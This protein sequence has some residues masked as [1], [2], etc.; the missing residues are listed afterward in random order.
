M[1]RKKIHAT[2]ADRFRAYRQRIKEK[3][4]ALNFPLEGARGCRDAGGVLSTQKQPKPK[5]PP[6]R[7][8]RLADIVDALDT[9]KDEYQ[10]WL[11]RL[12]ENLARSET[13]ERLQSTVDNM[14]EAINILDSLD[15]PRGFG[16]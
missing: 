11:E 8:K 2:P 4:T 6:S 10:E 14:Q 7:P 15:L 5:K 9:L 13:A 1:P 16:R 3:L 12:P